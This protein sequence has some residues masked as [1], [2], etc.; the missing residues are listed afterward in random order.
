VTIFGGKGTDIVGLADSFFNQT[1]TINGGPGNDTFV[2]TQVP[3]AN[4]FAG[5]APILNSVETSSEVSAPD[6]VAAFPWVSSLL[7]V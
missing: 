4:D 7:G 2:Q 6:F 5:G 3:F 1:V